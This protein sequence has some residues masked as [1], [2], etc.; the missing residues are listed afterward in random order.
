MPNISN[1]DVKAVIN[2]YPDAIQPKILYLRTLIYEVVNEVAAVGPIEETLKWNEPSYI[3]KS[4]S[5]LRIAWGGKHP[6]QYGMYFN[7]KTKLVDT[8]KERYKDIFKY[9]GNRAIIFQQDDSV[10]VPE[11]KQCVR[12]ALTYKKIKDL[13]ML[14]M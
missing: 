12:L 8:I 1:S 11:L 9:E 4:G 2:N 10:P 7:C 6:Q 13:P 3:A 5:T 14:G